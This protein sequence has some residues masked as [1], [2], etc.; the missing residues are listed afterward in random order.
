MIFRKYRVLLYYHCA[1]STKHTRWLDTKKNWGTLYA[2]DSKVNHISRGKITLCESRSWLDH[3]SFYRL[4]NLPGSETPIQSIGT[5]C[6]ACA[7]ASM[8]Q[9]QIAQT[10][11][12]GLEWAPGRNTPRYARSAQLLLFFLPSPVAR[13]VSITGSGSIAHASVSNPGYAVYIIDPLSAT[14]SNWALCGMI[15]RM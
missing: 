7:Q 14:K 11:Y 15:V 3:V 9:P 10:M 6:F 13:S 4:R 5:Q 1:K 12:Q 8:H 2:T